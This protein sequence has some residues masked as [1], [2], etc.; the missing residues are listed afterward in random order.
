MSKLA[1]QAQEQC[2]DFMRS[3]E[4]LKAELLQKRAEMLKSGNQDAVN[5]IVALQSSLFGLR[6]QAQNI[7]AAVNAACTCSLVREQPT[8]DEIRA[9]RAAQGQPEEKHVGMFPEQ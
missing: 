9:Q 1:Q 2:A 7:K 5:L 4:T 8:L 6:S 3:I